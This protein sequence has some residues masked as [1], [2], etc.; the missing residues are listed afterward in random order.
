MA[1]CEGGPHDDLTS[2]NEKICLKTKTQK[3]TLHEM[4]NPIIYSRFSVGIL[5]GPYLILYVYEI[6]YSED[7]DVFIIFQMIIY[8]A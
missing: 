5:Y 1:R 3:Y 6:K 4:S 8:V 2:N 7:C